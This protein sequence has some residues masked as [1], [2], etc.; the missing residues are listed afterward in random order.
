MCGPRGPASCTPAASTGEY[1][2]TW[3]PR[4]FLLKND[5]TFIGYKERPQDLEQRESPLN[6]FSVARKCVAAGGRGP[7]APAAPRGPPQPRRLGRQPQGTDS[8][9]FWLRGSLSQRPGL[10]GGGVLPTRPR[11]A[12]G[13]LGL[14]PKARTRGRPART[15]FGDLC[16][17]GT[18]SQRPQPRVGVCAHLSGA[19]A[20][21]V[22]HCWPGRLRRLNE[23]ARFLKQVLPW[24]CVPAGGWQV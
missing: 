15:S 3:R 10:V 18:G 13:L 7:H 9:R 16:Q 8:G 19:R 17:P 5:G 24:P 22:R 12:T 4:Y 2:K 6:N 11:G 14:L 20:G 21:W 23:R 1:I